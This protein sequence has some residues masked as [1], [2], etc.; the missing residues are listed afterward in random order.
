M[1]VVCL[2]TSR[3]GN[4]HLQQPQSET[5]PGSACPQQLCTTHTR[6]HCPAFLSPKLWAELFPCLEWGSRKQGHV[7]H[8]LR[9]TEPPAHPA[10]APSCSDVTWEL[11]EPLSCLGH[12]FSLEQW[13]EAS[14]SCWHI[15][16]ALSRHRE[17]SAPCRRAQ[18][19]SLSTGRL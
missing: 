1:P 16:A 14:Q 4:W 8:Y 15:Q 12:Q 11:W 7:K 13:L 9:A 17:S 19:T 2:H 18:S 5:V 10:P 6:R 3:G